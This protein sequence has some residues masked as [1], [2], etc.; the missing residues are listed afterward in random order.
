MSAQSAN[1][2]DIFHAR[3]AGHEGKPA[4]VRRGETVCSFGD[5]PR[6]IGRYRAA[7]A[8]LGVKRGDRV[9]VK[10]D[11]SPA[12]VF[13][14]LAVLASGA[15]FVPMNAAY[16]AAEVALLIE[17]AEPALLVHAAAT[18]VPDLA[19]APVRRITLEGDGSG[20]LPDL[21]ATLAPLDGVEPMGADDLAAILFTSGTTGRPK[22]AMLTHGN[23]S[24]NVAVLFETWRF[25]DADTILHALPLFHAHGLF[26]ALH[27]A[28]FSAATLRML[29]KFDAKAVIA[30]LPLVSVFMGVPTFYT[31]LLDN[32]AFTRDVAAARRLFISGSAPL[33]PSVF[34]AFEERTGHRILERYG[35]TEAVMI[36]SNP[37]EQAGRIPG[38]VGFPL[39][40]VSL[41]VIDGARAEVPTGEVGE[42]EIKGPNVCRGYWRRPEATAESFHADGY[43]LTGDTGFKD[44]EGR[45]T[46]SG[47]SKDLIISGGYNVYPAEIEMILAEVSGVQDVAVFGVPHPD[48]GE[49]VMAAVTLDGGAFDM[50]AMEA[51]IASRF[52]RFKQPKAVHV[53][54][55][56]P[57]NAMGKILKAKLRETYADSFA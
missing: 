29:P 34:N 17:D 54:D 53:L 27:L 36:T 7:L 45:V 52:A 13:T 31:R 41:R 1:L 11:N 57:R 15:I 43:F 55:E 19:E 8:Q 20:A 33:L 22:G 42:I 14:Y 32:P 38:T 28:L 2:I 30:E 49:A 16:T 21:A 48:F 3:H 51:L 40:G 26:V 46:I 24:S 56:F 5:L 18:A 4:L 25:S 6:S 23:L 50:G 12:F 10:A 35:M 37:Y 47:R 39:P 9:M 44:S